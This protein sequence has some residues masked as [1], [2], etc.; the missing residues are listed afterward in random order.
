MESS[1]KPKILYCVTKG[2]WGGAQKYVYDMATHMPSSEWDVVVASGEGDSLEKK[3]RESTVRFVRLPLLGRDVGVFKDI[4]A[5]FEIYSLVK[6]ESPDILHVNSSKAGILGSLVGRLCKVNK[7]VFTA[8]G[9]AF[10]EDRS[11]LGRSFILLLSWLT[12]LLSHTTIAVSE[13]V[14][15]KINGF[16]GSRGKVKV[17]RGGI[18]VLKTIPKKEAREKLDINP[19]R[20]TL[21]IGSI[22]ELHKNKGLSYAITAVSRLKKRG[23]K[24][25]YVIIGE[26]EERKD[27]ERLISSEKLEKDVLLVGFRE[28]AGELLKAFDIFLLPSITEA[29]GYALLEA[30]FAGIP[31][32]GSNVGGIPEIIKDRVNGILVEPR[33]QND[34]AAAIIFLTDHKEERIRM[35]VEARR[36]APLF[37]FDEMFKETVSL[38]KN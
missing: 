37:H 4:Q 17:I 26:G 38:Y 36:I 32:V 31:L 2:I 12:I 14:A 13:S 9:W 16:P 7:V 22:A 23:A 35:G 11:P 29:L 30:S 5:F 1:K 33:S 6:K 3:L 27:L 24:L 21:V 25:L 15:K 10:N 8:H 20:G 28:Q 19:Q 34:I 18:Q